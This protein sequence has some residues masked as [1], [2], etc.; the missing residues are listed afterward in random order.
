MAEWLRVKRGYGRMVEDE[1][2]GQKG[3]NEGMGEWLRV[4]RGYRK[5]G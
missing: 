4:K 1:N 2:R 5:M 3:Y